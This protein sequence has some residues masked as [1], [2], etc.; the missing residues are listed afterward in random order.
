L[1]YTSG[2]SR[3]KISSLNLNKEISEAIIAFTGIENTVSS[4][5]FIISIETATDINIYAAM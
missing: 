2:V 3:V 5:D 4:L 1:Y